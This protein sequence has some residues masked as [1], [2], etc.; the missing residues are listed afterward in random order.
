MFPLNLHFS[1]ASLVS[2]ENG[3]D[4]K[5]DFS[6]PTEEKKGNFLTR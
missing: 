5:M 6:S 1:G 2:A 4:E 3:K